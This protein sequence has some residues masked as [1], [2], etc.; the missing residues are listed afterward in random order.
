MAITALL[1]ALRQHSFVPISL[2][3]DGEG[4]I[5]SCQNTMRTFAVRFNPTG[6]GQHVPTVERAIRTIKSKVRGI[7][8]TLPY[9]LPSQW[10]VYLVQFV[11]M[12]INCM[13]QPKRDV[14]WHKI[15]L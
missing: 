6:P 5:A 3:S 9:G 11:V 4:A 10:L 14:Y 13:P 15:Q 7:L 12:R 8:N 2:L 1:S